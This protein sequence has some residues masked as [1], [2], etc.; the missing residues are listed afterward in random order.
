MR[1]EIAPFRVELF[2]A[3]AA[4]DFA[5]RH[6]RVD[7]DAAVPGP[8]RRK[9]VPLKAAD[10]ERAIRQLLFLSLDLLHAEHVGLLPREPAEESLARRGA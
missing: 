3:E 4:H 6:A 7:G 9:D 2:D 5:R 10:R 8:M 1:L